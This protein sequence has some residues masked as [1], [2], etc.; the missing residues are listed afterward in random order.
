MYFQLNFSL[1]L[2]MRNIP[3]WK[4]SKQVLVKYVDSAGWKF[5]LK[6]TLLI[7]KKPDLLTAEFYGYF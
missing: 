4:R 6:L 3:V 7:T 2:F 1:C 5:N